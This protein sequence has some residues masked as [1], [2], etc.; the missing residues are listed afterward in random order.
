[1][2]RFKTYKKTKLKIPKFI[3]LIPL[4]ILISHLYLNLSFKIINKN[5]LTNLLIT[6][7]YANLFNKQN[8]FNNLNNLIF[9]NV[10]GFNIQESTAE[11]VI[12]TNNIYYEDYLI[13]VY[14]TYQTDK[15]ERSNNNSYSVN[16]TVREASLIF[17]EYLEKEGLSTLVEQRNV[18]KTLKENKLNY[19]NIYKASRILLESSYNE[20][21][22][23]KYF[24]DLGRSETGNN[25]IITLNEKEY[26][27]ILFIIGTDN[28]NYLKNQTLANKLHTKINAKIKDLSKISLRGGT[29]YQGIYNED[30]NANTLL[31]QVGGKEN[32][33]NEVTNSLQILA[34]IMAIHIKQEQNET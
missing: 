30:F 7:T 31:I 17:K 29:G 6:N 26:A 1:M 15:Y 33:I 8:L 16:P 34:Q 32:T 23:L 20:Y 22:T 10:W 19:N 3:I 5:T 2:K 12:N 27:P 13:Y 25:K 14:N 9:K 4:I 24:I 28:N 11:P 18:A 21:K